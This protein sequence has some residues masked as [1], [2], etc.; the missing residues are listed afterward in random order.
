MNNGTITNNQFPFGRH[1]LAAGDAI[2]LTMK[3][4]LKG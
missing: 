3:I 2:N 1:R 4:M